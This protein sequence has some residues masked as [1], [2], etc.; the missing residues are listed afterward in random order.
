MNVPK[1]FWYALGG[2]IAGLVIENKSLRLKNTAGKKIRKT[3]EQ[4]QKKVHA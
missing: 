3:K 4:L 1:L 2:I